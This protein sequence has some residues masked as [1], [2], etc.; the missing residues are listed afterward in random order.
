MSYSKRLSRSQIRK[1]SVFLVLYTRGG[2]TGPAPAQQV[3]TGLS[4]KCVVVN[5]QTFDS[6]LTLIFTE[7]PILKF[8][9]YDAAEFANI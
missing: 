1:K 2:I 8:K 9:S 5:C 7:S 3:H 6:L 4:V